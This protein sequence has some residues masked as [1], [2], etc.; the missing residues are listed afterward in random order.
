MTIGD[1]VSSSATPRVPID[2]I[3]ATVLKELVE[4]IVSGQIHP[5]DAL[6]PEA[7]LSQEFGVS[8]TVI[9][10]SVKR[11]QEKGMVTVA[12]GRGTHVNPM[13]SWN[14]LDPLVISSLIGHDDALGI[15]DDLSV[16]R[17]ALEAAMAG[18]VAAKRTSDD[19]A[20]LTA[21]FEQ[22]ESVLHDSAAYRDA[23][24]RFHLL[25]MQLSGNILAENVA[26]GLFERALESSRYHGVDPAQAFEITHAEHQRIF[27][28]IVAGDREAARQAMEAH[29]LGS[30]DRRRLPTHPRD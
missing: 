24:V 21:S 17:G 11:L 6:P 22:M 26:H 23:D 18:A 28:A 27:D 3:G 7:V 29:I 12:Q 19:L 8:R 1:A 25:V 10:E 16:V 13:S 4:T 30:W 9:R 5:G 15:L 14:L 2:R 20:R